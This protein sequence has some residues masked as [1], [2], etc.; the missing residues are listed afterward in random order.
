MASKILK[1]IAPYTDIEV[2]EEHFNAKKQVS[3][4]AKVIARSLGL[5]E[6]TIKSIR[7]GGIVGR[8][9]VI[10]GFPY[11][12]VRLVHESIAR[13]AL[14]N[15]ALFA[16]MNI[17]NQP[18]GLY[19]MEDLLIPYLSLARDTKVA[20]SVVAGRPAGDWGWGICVG[21][22]ISGIFRGWM[23]SQYDESDVSRAIELLATKVAAEFDPAK[24]LNVIGIPTR[25]D[26][27]A[28]RLATMLEARGF[29]GIGRGIL[30]ITLYRDD[31]A[32]IGP[33]PLTRP[34]E[35]NMPLDD[36]PLVLVDD[37]L[38]TGRSVRSALNALV[39]FGRPSLI[40]LA[41]LIDR[42]GRELPIAADYVGILMPGLP[43]D[44]RVNLHLAEVD[45]K[46]E[47]LVEPRA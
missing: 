15:G 29:T 42:G 32:D 28:D 22:G 12:T 40:R 36:I 38:F 10:F 1:L 47:I 23:K 35:I 27:L 17:M 5:Q 9:E 20:S 34:T 13:E 30:D 46:D 31:L 7:A 2:I 18:N 33:A 3:G 4:T 21:W 14:G 19:A 24:P 26:T 44:V 11:Q 41:V 16:A 37:V 45:G 39:D 8:H 43:A 25:G 6:E